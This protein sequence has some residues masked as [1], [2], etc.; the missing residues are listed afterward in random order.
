MTTT[1]MFLSQSL[2]NLRRAINLLYG[3]L[4]GNV[5]NMD[6]EDWMYAYFVANM[7]WERLSA[8]PECAD[9]EQCGEQEEALDTVEYLRNQFASKLTEKEAEI[10]L[11]FIMASDYAIKIGSRRADPRV[12]DETKRYYGMLKSVADMFEQRC[13]KPQFN[14]RLDEAIRL[15]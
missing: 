3:I 2:T 8:L 5:H 6:P 11:Q 12:P 9:N 7:Y 1:T 4:Q 15:S 14:Q 10:W 13:N